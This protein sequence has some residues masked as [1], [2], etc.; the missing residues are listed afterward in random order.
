MRGSATLDATVPNAARFYD[1]LLGGREAFDA[2]R[3]LA[4]A[5]E[6]LYP[7]PGLPRQLARRNRL[8][9]ERA[10]SQAAH[11]GCRQFLVAGS[12]FPQPRDLHHVAAEACPAVSCAYLDEDPVVVSHGR[13]LTA[14]TRNVTYAHGDLA[15]P[16]KV[17]ADPDVLSVIDPGRPVCLVLGLVLHFRPAASARTVVEGYLDWLAPGSRVVVTVPHWTDLRLLERL[18]AVYAPGEVF[19]HAPLQVQSLFRD[20]SLL[21]NGV[22]IARGMGP[23]VLAPPAPAFVLAGVGRKG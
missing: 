4:A 18:Q 10:V 3:K 11:D 23:E 6:A 9:Q 16:G 14:E 8:Y 22:E 19:N 12:G 13:V 20:M 1:Y 7:D 21:G 15:Q 2:D 17:L 5:V